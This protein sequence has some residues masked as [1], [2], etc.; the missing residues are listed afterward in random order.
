MDLVSDG[1]EV[2]T[3]PG[4]HAPTRLRVEHGPRPLGIAVAQP[5]LSWWLPAGTTGQA[6]YRI[7]ATVDGEVVAS[8]EI[9][10][11]SPVLR[12]WP[13]ASLGS[14]AR[15]A[16]RVQVRTD[17]GWSPWSAT[18]EVE[19][20]LLRVADWDGRFIG[21][22]GGSDALAPRGERG[23]TYLRRRFRVDGAVAGARLY[24]TAHGL[25]EL[26]LDGRRV[27]DLE[28]TPGFTAYRSHLEV[29][30]FD[31]T[32]LL[33][34]GEHTLVATVTDGWW[35]GSV[36]H[37]R[38]E[39]C[40]GDDVALL[41]QLEIDDPTGDR[42]V[43]ATDAGWEV[44]TDGPIVASDLIEGE[45]VDLRVPFPPADGWRPA[46]VVG[47]PDARLTASPA[48]PTRRVER[49]R[50]VSVTRLD[51]ERQV[52]DLGANVNGWLGLDGRALG[53]A[54]TQ[55]RLR[56]G[57]R[58]GADGDVDTRHLEPVDFRSG[59]HLGAGQVDEV[60]SRGADGP[61]VELRHTTHG[62]RYVAVDGA[63]DLGRE[64]VAGVMVHTDL[65]RTGWFRC[66]DERLNALHD[67]AVLSFR[68][69]ACE[70]PTDCPQ[71]E[72]A[73]WTGDWQLFQPTAA[74]LYD[75]AGFTDRWLRDLAADQWDDGRV[76]NFVPDP[77]PPSARRGIA[78]FLTGSAGWGDA[79]V[80]VPYQHWLAYGDADLLARQYPSMQAW[81]DF[82]L[83]RA[84]EHRHPT[85]IERRPEPAPHERFLW[86]IGFHWG[87]W[88]EPG[89]N[90]HEVFT[91]EADL[92]IVATAYLHRSLATLAETAE[93]LGHGTNDDRYR[94]LAAEVR[95]AW[96]AEFVS[97]DGAVAPATQANL[98]RALAFGLVDEGHRARVAADLV[99]LVRAAGTHVGTG[100]LAT[101]LLLSTLADN[102]YLDVAYELLFQT[103]P[104]SWLAMIEAGATTIWEH[105]EGLDAAGH[106]SLN[107]YSKGAVISFLHEHVAGLLP[108]PGVPAYERFDVRP[109]LGGGLS[110]AEARLDTPHGRIACSWT[111]DGDRFALEAVV[112]PGTSARVTLPD[113]AAHDR[114]PGAHR[115]EISIDERGLSA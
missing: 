105:W 63:P 56:H 15:V 88:C 52:V 107:H 97:P 47:D 114:G 68:G 1:V 89:G 93:L 94:E 66:S 76:P 49:Y 64:D 78:A 72:R 111:L 27:G 32:E 28:L 101:P 71:R 48:P 8:G 91:G 40:Y 95:H 65:V 98:V 84:A 106:G 2:T 14:R 61:A 99:E 73:G 44:T 22:P 6:A 31:V 50:P 13:F 67:A 74:F 12:P 86:D 104:P 100:F 25:Y 7:E 79:A 42:T 9:A 75:V 108:R 80:L 51:A 3:G 113:G 33:S 41:A 29:Q 115:F 16:W 18:S 102:G 109:A 103:T 21:D 110:A 69:N 46:A 58:L 82:A 43:V 77:Y 96:Q 36:G 34:P 19:T 55:L 57:E 39:R 5:R 59:E 90:P 11:T 26:H 35:R 62:F 37:N 83:R 92:A 17:A 54:G 24:A 10:S 38:T 4:D 81:V 53:P 23:A 60:V 112:A 30:T 45:R 70:I 85:R 20:G 87:E